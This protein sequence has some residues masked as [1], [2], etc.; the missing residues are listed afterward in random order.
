MARNSLFSHHRT[1]KAI[2]YITIQ[3]RGETMN[4]Y[5]LFT[6]INTILYHE[7]Q[8]SSLNICTQQPVGGGGFIIFKK[9]QRDP[10][11]NVIS[12]TSTFNTSAIVSVQ[13][14]KPTLRRK[15]STKR[16]GLLSLVCAQSQ[17]KLLEVKIAPTRRLCKPVLL[18]F[19]RIKGSVTTRC[20]PAPR[21]LKRKS[22]I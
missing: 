11:L 9:K 10:G 7:Q 22:Q 6:E 21:I 1:K 17:Q 16:K 20:K 8:T 5:T 14:W 19:R 2:S 12:V 13:A 15:S 18:Y 3:G 4:S